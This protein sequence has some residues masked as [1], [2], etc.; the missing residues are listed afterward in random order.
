MEESCVLVNKVSQAFGV[1]GGV[2]LLD[3]HP[4]NLVASLEDCHVL[5]VEAM[6]FCDLR[7]HRLGKFWKHWKC[8]T[9][10]NGDS[11]RDSFVGDGATY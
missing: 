5:G 3:D 4:L 6:S 7:D 1:D 10:K 2:D 8:W 11:R 9:F